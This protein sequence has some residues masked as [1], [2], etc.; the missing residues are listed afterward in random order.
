MKYSPK[1]RILS[2]FHKVHNRLSIYITKTQGKIKLWHPIKLQKIQV[3][4][5]YW[6]SLSWLMW[7]INTPVMKEKLER[8]F[9]WSVLYSC[10]PIQHI[11]ND[12][13]ILMSFIAS[14]FCPRLSFHLKYDKQ[15]TLYSHQVRSELAKLRKNVISTS[16]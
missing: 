3:I 4:E 1:T 8:I 7:S 15:A 12:I 9:F 14:R 6:D 10:V 5:E 16:F 2:I 11:S 13:F